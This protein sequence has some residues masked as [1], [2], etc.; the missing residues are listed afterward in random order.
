MS[1]I[2]E[3][4]E[5]A[6]SLYEK[7]TAFIS[8]TSLLKLRV[9]YEGWYTKAMALVKQVV[10]ERTTDFCEAYRRKSK[11]LTYASYSI[12]DYLHGLVV[13][14]GG[15][16]VFDVVECFRRRLLVQIGIVH[17]AQGFI[18]SRLRDIRTELQAEILDGDVDGAAALLK[19]GHLRSAGVICGVALE[20][21]FKSI[22]ERRTLRSKRQK[23]TLG[24]W[25]ELLKEATVYD[26]PTWRLI[27][28]LTDIRNLCGHKAEREPRREEVEDLIRGTRKILKEVG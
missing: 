7:G 14:R 15:E 19:S 16:P 2:D 26:I 5:E 9:K 18:R 1:R 11:E 24:D 13:T 28:H 4:E 22:A 21:H 20:A 10:P 8:E 17:A 12:D 23:P 6:K 3:I 27:Q 25:N